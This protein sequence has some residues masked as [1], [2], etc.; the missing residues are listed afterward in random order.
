MRLTKPS[1]K[2][3]AISGLVSEIAHERPNAEYL[4]GVWSDSL[5]MDL[6]WCTWN[7]KYHAPEASFRLNQWRAPSWRS[8]GSID[9]EVQWPLSGY[10]CERENV[11]EVDL[12]FEASI[13]PGCK[14][15]TLDATTGPSA[16]TLELSGKTFKGRLILGFLEVAT[17]LVD[18]QGNAF[19]VAHVL[20]WMLDDDH[21]FGTTLELDHDEYDLQEAYGG[22]EDIEVLCMRMGVVKQHGGIYEHTHEYTMVLVCVDRATRKYRRVGM[23]SHNFSD[24]V[25][26]CWDSGGV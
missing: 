1:D 13:L 12:M 14:L 3:A 11:T 4:A 19:F 5:K 23:A 25:S 24:E 18:L 17:E 20:E 7:N 15:E 22:L 26:S 9:A 16:S 6:L 10:R 8:W 21:D 2:L